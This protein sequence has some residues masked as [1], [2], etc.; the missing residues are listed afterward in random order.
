MTSKTVKHIDVKNGKLVRVNL[1]STK[2]KKIA[3]DR[4][5][6]AWKERSK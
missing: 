3:A 2:R 5:A 6:K 1:Y 4:E